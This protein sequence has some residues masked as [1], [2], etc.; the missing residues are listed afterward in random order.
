MS[1][2]THP[3]I[4]VAESAKRY[5]QNVDERRAMAHA[6]YN[7]GYRDDK[8]RE[9]FHH[10]M[11]TVYNI[12]AATAKE[13]L[14]GIDAALAAGA[15]IAELKSEVAKRREVMADIVRTLGHGCCGLS[16][17]DI[18][19]KIYTLTQQRDEL[20]GALKQIESR[21]R[22]DSPEAAVDW[23]ANIAASAI[24]KAEAKE[25]TP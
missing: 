10:G 8:E 18:V 16:H 23:M 6:T 15:E 21:Q 7:G 20:L 11:D 14:P 13:I 9:I 4:E 17:D 12:M 24:A 22:F 1:E 5:F 3:L 2:I 19:P 25:A